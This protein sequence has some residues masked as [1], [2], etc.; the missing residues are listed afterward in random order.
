M[1]IKIRIKVGDVEIEYEGP[2]DY[3][4]KGIAEIVAATDALRGKGAPPTEVAL[5][6]ETTEE[7]ETPEEEDV[8][9]TPERQ[10]LPMTVSSIAKTLQCSTGQD[11]VV[12]A[13]V[14]L[15]LVKQEDVFT[16]EQI[17]LEMKEAGRYYK[18]N[19]RK[20]LSKYLNAL[21]RNEVLLEVDEGS[22]SV[23]AGTLAQLED[24]LGT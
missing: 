7:Q 1:E 6:E 24:M 20:S 4:R 8:S 2:E 5:E 11:L 12:A 14:S 23:P 22:Y 16:R 18:D 21:V 3:L 15:T 10:P 17:R 13:C 9:L 19:Y